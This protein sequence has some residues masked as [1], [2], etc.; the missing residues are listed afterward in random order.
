MKEEFIE[1]MVIG[2]QIIDIG[3]V[4]CSIDFEDGFFQEEFGLV[5]GDYR[6]WGF[7]YWKIKTR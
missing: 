6:R 1:K 5:L 3:G 7:G 4:R 2:R